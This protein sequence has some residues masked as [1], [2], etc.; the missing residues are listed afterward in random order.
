M[1]KKEIQIFARHFF[2]LGR[3]LFLFLV[4]FF[5]FINNLILTVMILRID[6]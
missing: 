2:F 5:F 1:K 4:K 3:N 6:D